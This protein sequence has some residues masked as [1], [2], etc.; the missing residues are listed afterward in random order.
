MPICCNQAL[1]HYESCSRIRQYRRARHFN[2]SYEWKKWSDPPFGI[3]VV[4][5]GPR[6][7]KIVVRVAA[8]EDHR[9]IPWQQDCL[10][11]EHF[12]RL[13]FLAAILC[14]FLQ[15]RF[16]CGDI[17]RPQVFKSLTVDRFA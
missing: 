6:T 16:C 9:P 10:Q 7:V 5:A 14:Q 11:A 13:N 4:E 15:S 3:V 8:D 12:A 2:T 1:A 17:V